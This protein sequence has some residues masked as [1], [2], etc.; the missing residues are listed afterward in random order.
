VGWVLGEAV[1]LVGEAVGAA[2][3]TCTQQ[4]ANHIS[5]QMPGLVKWM[6]LLKPLDVAALVCLGARTLTLV[7]LVV[8]LL[9]GTGV[10]TCMK[11][12]RG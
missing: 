3:G 11:P 9:L 6:P 12:S 10:G 7:G 2:E 4:I 8:G 1:R 5:R